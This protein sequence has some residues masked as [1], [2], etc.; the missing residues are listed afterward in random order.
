MDKLRLG[1]DVFA[2]DLGDKVASTQFKTQGLATIEGFEIYDPEAYQLHNDRLYLCLDGQFPPCKHIQHGTGIICNREHACTDASCDRCDVITVRDIDPYK[3]INEISTMIERYDRLERAIV[4]TADDAT[5]DEFMENAE[6]LIGYPVCI[7]DVNLDVVAASKTRKPIG[8]PLWES[9]LCDEKPLR[10]EIIDHLSSELDEER[11]ASVVPS[12]RDVKLAGWNMLT[13]NIVEN[14]HPVASLWAFQTKPHRSLGKAEKCLL[15]WLAGCVGAWV[16]G[17]KV[18]N[19]GRGKQRERFLLDLVDGIWQDDATIIEAARSVGIDRMPAPEHMMFVARLV[20][21]ASHAGRYLKVL[22]VLEEGLPGMICALRGQDIV[23]I[24]GVDANGYLTKKQIGAIDKL[25][26]NYGC[27]AFIGTPYKQLKDSPLVMRQLL[28]CFELVEL[29]S[30]NKGLHEYCDYVL[31]QS[32]QLVV[33]M[34]PKETM[35]HPMIRKL[36]AYD[37]ANNTDYLDTFKVYL[38]NRC[39]MTDTAKQLHMHRNTLLH[40]IKRIEELLDSEL[41]DWELR[42][43]LLL[44]IDYLN[45]DDPDRF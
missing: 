12:M 5:L 26:R 30:E 13:Y 10:C 24:V 42:R 8:N 2:R 32:M 7:L 44:S 38:N 11:S 16:S 19:I 28:D 3:L 40:R 20:N 1:I 43:K 41:Y 35:L 34:Q 45:L 31:Q 21:E 33:S 22:N 39:N 37:L 9:I 14:G 29:S 25:C 4:S 15:Q 17:T 6:M 27:M 18:L 23:G 36:V